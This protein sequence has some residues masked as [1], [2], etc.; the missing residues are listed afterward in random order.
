M[1]RVGLADLVF[2]YNTARIALDLCHL[3]LGKITGSVIDSELGCIVQLCP[4]TNSGLLEYKYAMV[5]AAPVTTESPLLH[6]ECIN[7]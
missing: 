5:L 7:H 1:K 4:H 3:Y 2:R 6:T